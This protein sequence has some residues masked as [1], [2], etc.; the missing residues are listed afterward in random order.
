MKF[1]SNKSFGLCFTVLFWQFGCRTHRTPGSI[2][3][4]TAVHST[5]FVSCFAADRQTDRQAL[6]YQQP[7]STT[8]VG[9]TEKAPAFNVNK[10]THVL[11]CTHGETEQDTIS[12]QPWYR[13]EVYKNLCRKIRR[14]PPAPPPRPC[15]PSPAFLHL[16]NPLRTH[17]RTPTGMVSPVRPG[18]V[19]NEI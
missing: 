19:L 4:Y 17:S 14:S 16:Q 5:L 13:N 8:R 11:L 6:G 12:R 9:T 10:H 7:V 2:G 15:L 1:I 3:G 18:D